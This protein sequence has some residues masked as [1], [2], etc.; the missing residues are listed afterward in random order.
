MFSLKI[1]EEKLQYH[2][3]DKLVNDMTSLTSEVKLK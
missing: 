3:G 2:N 1:S